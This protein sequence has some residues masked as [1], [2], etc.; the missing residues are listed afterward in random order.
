[1]GVHCSEGEQWRPVQRD[2]ILFRKSLRFQSNFISELLPGWKTTELFVLQFRLNVSNIL[3]TEHL[4][5]DGIETQP[6]KEE[7][8]WTERE[9]LWIADEMGSVEGNNRFGNYVAI[10]RYHVIC[11]KSTHPTSHCILP[12]AINTQI[13]R[14][15]PGLSRINLELSRGKRSHLNPIYL[16]MESRFDLINGQ[17]VRTRWRMFWKS[18]CQFFMRQQVAAEAPAAIN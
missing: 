9:T 17:R 3:E 15:D 2:G 16:T 14:T 1:M 12:S 5:C 18:E 7:I 6:G 11:S 8:E 13:E 4:G 10:G